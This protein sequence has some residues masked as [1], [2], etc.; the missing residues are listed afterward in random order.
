MYLVCESQN[1]RVKKIAHV[2]SMCS[3]R[4]AHVKNTMAITPVNEKA[5]FPVMLMILK[6]NFYLPFIDL[7]INLIYVLNNTHSL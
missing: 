6:L 4:L 3:V 7:E 1:S 5:L 2:D